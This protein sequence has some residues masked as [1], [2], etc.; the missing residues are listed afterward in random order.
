MSAA[1]YAV[2]ER[3][4]SWTVVHD[5]EARD[6][7]ATM[8][9]AFEAVIAATIAFRQ[10]HEIHLSVPGKDAGNRTILGAR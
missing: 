3:G 7:Y 4:E 8:E 9:A 6:Y 10:G 1:S 5:G 2:A